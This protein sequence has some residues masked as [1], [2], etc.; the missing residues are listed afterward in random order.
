MKFRTGL[1]ERQF[2]DAFI[3]VEAQ[4]VLIRQRLYVYDNVVQYF[5]N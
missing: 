4:L 5:K 2:S 1:K 3:L